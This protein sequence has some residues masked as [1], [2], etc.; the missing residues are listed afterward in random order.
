MR[1]KPTLPRDAGD[2]RT[3]ER[4]LSAAGELFAERG[5]RGATVRAIAAR[6]G[7]NL[8]AANYHFGGKPKLYAEVLRSSFAAALAR[9]PPDGGLPANAPAADRLR[10]FIRSFLMRA[11]GDGRPSWQ[12]RLLMRELADPTEAIDLVVRDAIQ[13]QFE[14]VAG[15]VRELLG[16][17]ASADEVALTVTSV[18]GQCLYWFTADAVIARLPA[19][20]A[21]RSAD[22]LEAIARHVHAFTRAAL[23]RAPERRR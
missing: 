8:A 16:P 11:R 19:L 10:A 14:R 2:E 1:S 5:F 21:Y 3:R 20:K 17:R 18:V 7:A 4:L 9:H 23:A 13:P 12:G 22:A 15:I 6:A